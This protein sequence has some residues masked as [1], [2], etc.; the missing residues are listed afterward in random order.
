MTEIFRQHGC[1]WGVRGGIGP[2]VYEFG[3]VVATGILDLSPFV[4]PVLV[5][6]LGIIADTVGR[7]RV[8]HRERYMGG[9]ENWRE[10]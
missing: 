9:I 2:T 4:F 1:E 5:P 10:K 3:I 7:A 8:G 6:E